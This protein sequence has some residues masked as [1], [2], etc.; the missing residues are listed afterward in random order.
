MSILPPLIF[1]IKH[2]YTANVYATFSILFVST[3]LNCF[4]CISHLIFVAITYTSPKPI[5]ATAHGQP[6]R[7]ILTF[8]FLNKSYMSF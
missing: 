6:S 3:L 7:V 5:S 1:T 4:V 8:V 2:H